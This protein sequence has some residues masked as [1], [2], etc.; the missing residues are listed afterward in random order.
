MRSRRHPA[1]PIVA[2]LAAA[3][4][5]A[6]S[7]SPKSSGEKKRRTVLT[8]EWDDARV[9]KEASVDVEAQVGLLGDPDLDAYLNG[10]GRKLLRGV[11]RRPFDY[12]FRVV[13]QVEP[14]AF[15]LPGGY[16]FISRGLLVLANDEDEL[17]CV[18]GHEITHAARRHAARQQAI[19]AH[20][21]PIAMPWSKAATMAGYGRDMEREADHGGQKL[22]AAA[23]YDPMGMST[24]LKSLTQFE[25]LRKGA[26]RQASFFDS[27]PG[28]SERAAVNAVRA[29]EMRWRRNPSLGDPRASLLR[30][31][32]G[33]AVG[34]R[35]QAGIFE[36]SRFIHP[37][38]GFQIRFPPGWETANTNQAVGASAPRGEAVVFLVADLPAGDPREVAEGWL[39]KEQEDR[40]ME[41]EESKA[42]KVGHTDAW[43]MR[44]KMP[45]RGGSAIAYVTF[46]PYRG[47]TWRVT[48]M[49]RSSAAKRYLGRTL[50]TARSFGPL[51]EKERRSVKSA[52]L[53]IVRARSG[54]NLATLSRRSGDAWDVSTTAVYNGIFS[55]HRFSG[56]EQV[57]IATVE[58]YVPSGD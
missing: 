36:G 19:M 1:L 40:P 6:C 34:Q 43:R 50:S 26:S 32:D 38:L 57:K 23:G 8:T 51:S 18:I 41:L 54:E 49:S 2:C 17:A 55:N 48:G 9:G 3:V 37:D 7:S 31:T 56:G 35:P 10:I 58:P 13:D 52:R 5:A 22:C 14:N 28:S 15:A 11:P 25:R 29:S 20:S 4:L 46:I 24:F 33:I 42:V 16:I 44:V 12:Q 53:R 47:I 21:S 30:H 45:A 27:H 39:A